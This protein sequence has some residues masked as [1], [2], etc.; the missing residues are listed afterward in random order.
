MLARAGLGGAPVAPAAPRERTGSRWAEG[1][2]RIE[3]EDAGRAAVDAGKAPPHLF[4]ILRGAQRIFEPDRAIVTALAKAHAGRDADVGP[5]LGRYLGGFVA[6]ERATEKKG[7]FDRQAAF[8]RA[9]AASALEYGARVCVSFAPDGAPVVEL[10]R[11]SGIPGLDRIAVDA[12][13]RAAERR[14]AEE[15]KV[16]VR[17]CYRFSARLM[18]LPPLPVFACWLSTETWRPACSYPLKQLVRTSISL[19]GVEPVTIAGP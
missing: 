2:R 18:R 8:N 12:A 16:P 9:I 15:R 11:R 6:P 3:R 4:D 17:G 19:D 14:P 7:P 10:D 13:T 5:W 1:L